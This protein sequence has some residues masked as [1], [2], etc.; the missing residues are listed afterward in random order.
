M[1]NFQSQKDCWESIGFELRSLGA[2]RFY[3]TRTFQDQIFVVRHAADTSVLPNVDHEFRVCFKDRESG[4][5]NSE[6]RYAIGLSALQKLITKWRR[7][8]REEPHL[9]EH[10]GLLTNGYQ[11]RLTS[12]AYAPERAR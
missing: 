10:S 11:Q 12:I 7:E 9:R 8:L 3:L 6:T 2:G 5:L 4:I 1:S